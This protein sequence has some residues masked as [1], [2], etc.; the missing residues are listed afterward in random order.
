[1]FIILLYVYRKLYFTTDCQST[2]VLYGFAI[3][4]IPVKDIVTEMNIAAIMTNVSND[5]NFVLNTLCFF[6]HFA[7]EGLFSSLK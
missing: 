4:P 2:P 5:F 3:K 1:M 6:F 7:S